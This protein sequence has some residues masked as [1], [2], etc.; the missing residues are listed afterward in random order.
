MAVTTV[1]CPDCG[2]PVPYGR[3]SCV[4]CGALLAS[5][6]GAPRPPAAARSADSTS[7][8]PRSTKASNG[9]S[10]T[11]S[12]RR[13]PGRNGSG[14]TA[15]APAQAGPAAQPIP[16]T[17][18]PPS[19]E[20]TADPRPTSSERSVA[21]DRAAIARSPEPEPRAAALVPLAA[22]GP[23]LP[24]AS[25]APGGPA[26]PFPATMVGAPPPFTPAVATTSAVAPVP[27]VPATLGGPAPMAQVQ[28][29][30]AYLPPSATFGDDPSARPSAPSPSGDRS[31]AGASGS[32]TLARLG[33]VRLEAPSDLPA[34]FVAA[35]SVAA[36]VGFVLPWGSN[37]MIGGGPEADFFSRWGLANA[38][39]V[40]PVLLAFGA[41]Y[42]QLGTDVP[43]TALRTGAVGLALG[44]LLCGF[45]F[46]YATSAF[47]LGTGGT[48]VAIG[49]I[50]LVVGGLLGLV[51][52]HRSGEP[53]V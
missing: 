34:W 40:I 8:T 9:R 51:P 46:V 38:A 3:L 41:L 49:G 33:D 37:G 2:A 45:A 30:G 11:G 15:Q 27:G 43:R 36:I 53:P 6:A 10:R 52:R 4:A 31:T 14:D 44:G 13:S 39:N 21:F 50:G 17:P 48:V 5:V 26:Q 25:F 47:G 35:G 12:A 16:P 28:V 32:L 23:G 29:A 24:V 18:E 20:A 22:S 7:E 1:S 42:L 19:A